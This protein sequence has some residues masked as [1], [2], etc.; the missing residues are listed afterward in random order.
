MKLTGR[1]QR[2]FKADWRPLEQ[3]KADRPFTTPQVLWLGAFSADNR[4][5]VTSCAEFAYAWDVDTG[6]LRRKI[7]RTHKWGCY[8]ALAPDGKTLA[9]SDQRSADDYG[10]DTIRL[11]DL[12]TG[13]QVLTLEPGD[14]RA[15]VLAFSPD[16]TKLFTGFHRGSAIVWDVQRGERG[17][18]TKK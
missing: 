9:T 2:R 5:L 12:D 18:A 8:L 10:V 3:Q 15:G 11:Y 4:T 1:E 17:P 6:K 14:N 16:G 13:E 7:R